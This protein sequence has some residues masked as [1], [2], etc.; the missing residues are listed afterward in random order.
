MI[1]KYVKSGAI[2]HIAI[3]SMAS[4]EGWVHFPLSF[5]KFQL[6]CAGVLD[7]SDDE[8]VDVLSAGWSRC[9]SLIGIVV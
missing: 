2:L 7:F 4:S 6:S 5:E 8:P 9:T 3:V 1:M